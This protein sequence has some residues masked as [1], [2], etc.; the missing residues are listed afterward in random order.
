MSIRLNTEIVHKKLN[1]QGKRTSE[2]ECAKLHIVKLTS[3]RI[4]VNRK[5]AEREVWRRR[6]VVTERRKRGASALREQIVVEHRWRRRGA[7]VWRRWSRLRQKRQH[8][9]YVFP[10]PVVHSPA[11]SLHFARYLWNLSLQ[12]TA[13]VVNP[14]S[15]RTELALSRSV[16]ALR[17]W[18]R[19]C[20]QVREER[21]RDVRRRVK[22]VNHNVSCGR[23]SP[24]CFLIVTEAHLTSNTFLTCSELW[25]C[26]ERRAR[27]VVIVVA[28]AG[29]SASISSARCRR[30]GGRRPARQPI[31]DRRRHLWSSPPPTPTTTPPHCCVFTGLW[32]SD[33]RV[34]IAPIGSNQF[35]NL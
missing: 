23:P 11:C 17:V 15:R 25:T 22:S 1:F 2:T 6:G 30:A 5:S 12:L 9:G 16:D 19:R 32:L 21:L 35:F 33:C 10:V 34:L 26:P 7:C 28:V 27:L 20:E 18:R 4:M 13:S 8:S 29:Q 24:R 14:R 31:S 3:E